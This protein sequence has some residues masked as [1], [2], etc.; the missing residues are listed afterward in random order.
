[1]ICKECNGKELEYDERLGEQVCKTCGFVMVEN[2][3]EE[4]VSNFDKDG[5]FTNE[6]TKSLG[7]II[8]GRSR[9]KRVQQTT[10]N[11]SH[12]KTIQY[13]LAISAEFSPSQNI[14]DEMVN[15]YMT[16]VRAHK[17]RGYNIDERIAAVVFFTF[18]ENN[19]AIK[20]RDIAEKEKEQ[21]FIWDCNKVHMYLS[22]IC[23]EANIIRNNSYV[24]AVIYITS[25]LRNEKIKQVTVREV[26]KSYHT[27]TRYRRIK[28]MLN[29]DFRKWDVDEFIN[30]VYLEEKK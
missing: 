3:F 17:F 4:T 1:M 18:K 26:T 28:Q 29:I 16:L 5:N 30:G 10:Q 22:P 27:I 2:I 21:D 14:R 20:L 13:L 23:E 19:R 15:N 11:N 8:G 24:G 6:V 9:L 7:S 25:I 12:K